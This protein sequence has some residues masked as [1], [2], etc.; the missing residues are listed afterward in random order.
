MRF[1]FLRQIIY[2]NFEFFIEDTSHHRSKLLG[3]AT[4]GRHIKTLTSMINVCGLY[5]GFP[6]WK[7][8]GG[9]RDHTERHLLVLVSHLSK[10]FERCS[11]TIS[12]L[13]K[14]DQKW[15]DGLAAGGIAQIPQ[16]LRRE[17][18]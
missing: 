3:E 12:Q 18:I 7:S 13:V 9:G 6:R 2:H 8:V 1:N 14:E 11:I 16:N 17:K 15:C 10:V 4:Q 5:L